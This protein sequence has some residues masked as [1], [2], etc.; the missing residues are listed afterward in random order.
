MRRG[1]RKRRVLWFPPI[2]TKVGETQEAVGYNT[3][4]LEVSGNPSLPSSVAQIQIPLT[5]D[6]GQEAL[7]ASEAANALIPT[8]ADLEESAWRLRRVV[9]K[10]FA[11]YNSASNA[12][13]NNTAPPA[14]HFMAGLMVRRVDS[15]GFPDPGDVQLGNRDDY[16]DPW[17]WRR[18]WLLGRGTNE[19]FFGTLGGGPTNAANA[20]GDPF[21]AFAP[22]IA[23]DFT[24]FPNNNCVYGSAL[25]GPHVDAKTNRIIGPE[26]RLI[27]HME[28]YALPIQG[29]TTDLVRLGRVSG[30]YDLRLL[31]VT[32]KASNRRNATR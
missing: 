9:G 23:Y 21:T 14:V 32:M 12:R 20:S 13:D 3:F 8:L 15:T 22:Q 4:S 11:T 18:T 6:F 10:I 24:Q 2:G 7:L 28:A 17:L 5:F 16:D 27:L 1:R 29:F 31:G 30:M 25:D 26:D 19:T